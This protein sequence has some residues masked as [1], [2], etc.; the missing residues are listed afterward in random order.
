MADGDLRKRAKRKKIR[1]TF[2]NGKIICHPNVT[3]TFIAVLREIGSERFSEI[4]LELC[5]LPLLGHE[6][7]PRYK[8]WMKPICEGW[9]LNAQSNTDQK[10]IQLRS[11]NDSLSLGLNI[12]IG[13]DFETQ[14]KV[15]KER[16][17]K[18]KAKL[19]V[20][21]PDGEYIANQSSSETFL[22]CL[23]KF[24]IDEIM[25]KSIEWCGDSMITSYK[26]S[27]RQIQVD[28]N[29]WAIVPNTTKERAKLLRVIAAHFR[30]NLE[31][32]IL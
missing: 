3:D 6:I 31:I 1:V 8:D 20:K 29:R 32:T 2:P 7:Y 5:H 16:S 18:S 4:T 19:L 24:G 9:Y 26:V 12:E 27:D 30:I 10:Y 22:E 15:V 14:E 11:I 28:V 17:S 23:W 21:F 25:R 13:E